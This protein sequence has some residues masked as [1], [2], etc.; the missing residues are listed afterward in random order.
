MPRVRAL[1]GREAGL[2]ARVVQAVFRLALG[3]DLNP[4]KVEAHAPRT[5]LA[6]FLSNALM[7]TGRWSLGADLRLL[8]RVRVAALNGCPF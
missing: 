5:L 4:Y 8:V 3:R 6:S 2:T 7:S 1:S